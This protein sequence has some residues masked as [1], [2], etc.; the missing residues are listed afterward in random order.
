L[1]VLYDPAQSIID[2]R[3]AVSSHLRFLEWLGRP[4]QP[5]SRVLDFGCGAGHSVDVMLERGLDA[6]GC[7]VREWWGKDIAQ[8]RADYGV[9]YAPPPH[10]AR[11]LR[12]FNSSDPSLPFEKH[13]FD[14]CF[15]DQVLEHVFDHV[16]AFRQIASVLKPNGISVHRFPGPNMLMEGHVGL[17]FPAMCH[18]R[19]YLMIWALLGR[20][21]P[22]QRGQSWREALDSN[23]QLMQTVKFRSKRYLRACAQKANVKIAFFEADEMR[24]RDVGVAA[25]LVKR[26]QRFG[27][28]RAIAQ[29]LSLVS[30]R[31]MV[32]TRP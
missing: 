14:L 1:G 9:T 29:L 13:S 19:P 26:M 30:Q 15:S 23:V 2:K 6:Y 10:V 7:D 17:P 12:C 5:V 22:T 31:Y 8:L 27:I 3:Q 32:L 18:L 24:L 4:L 25:R 20:R 28:D 21:S 11:R 16:T